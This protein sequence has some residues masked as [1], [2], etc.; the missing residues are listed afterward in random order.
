MRRTRTHCGTSR[1]LRAISRLD[2]CRELMRGSIARH[3]SHDGGSDDRCRGRAR[4]ALV[5]RIL[6][7]AEVEWRQDAAGRAVD[8][9]CLVD[10]GTAVRDGGGGV[11][12]VG[13]ADGLAEGGGAGLGEEC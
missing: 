2:G 1:P 9:G 3:E 6:G 13:V 11:R 8:I 12:V 10:G 7:D 4:F 5:G